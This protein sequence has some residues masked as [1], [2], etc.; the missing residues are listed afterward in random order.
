MFLFFQNSIRHNLSLN[1]SFLKVPR[2]KNEPGKGGFWCLDPDYAETRPDGTFKKKRPN[3]ATSPPCSKAKK[4]KPSSTMV[5]STTLSS[6]K[7]NTISGIVGNA[8]VNLSTI[9]HP[10]LQ[11]T[12]YA[13]TSTDGFTTTCPTT[14]EALGPLDGSKVIIHHPMPYLPPPPS[15]NKDRN[16]DNVYF[17]TGGKSFNK[18][19]IS[20]TI[21]RIDSF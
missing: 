7:P 8:N 13:I 11:R 21:L 18:F 15:I 10:N 12:H 2:S 17:S 19:F 3:K 9:V 14:L 4:S 6:V 16:V 1:K 20:A 5:T